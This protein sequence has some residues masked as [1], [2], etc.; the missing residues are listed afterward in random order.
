MDKKLVKGVALIQLE[1]DGLLSDE[2]FA[3]LSSL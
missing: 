1:L 2:Q 3:E